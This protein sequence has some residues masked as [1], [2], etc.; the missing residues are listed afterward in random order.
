VA[1]KW[2]WLE[3]GKLVSSERASGGGKQQLCNRSTGKKASVRDCSAGS[4]SGEQFFTISLY[5][6][7]TL[8][9]LSPGM[10]SV[11]AIQRVSERVVSERNEGL[12]ECVCVLRALGWVCIVW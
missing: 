2:L 12:S 1:A 8:S 11:R 7:F 6:S 9:S 5:I 3:R 4:P 10:V